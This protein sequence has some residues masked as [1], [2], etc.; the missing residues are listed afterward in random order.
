MENMTYEGCGLNLYGIA[1][2]VVAV[3]AATIASA[4]LV[5]YGLI[6]GGRLPAECGG[7]L[8]QG[9]Q[10]WCGVKWLVLQSFMQQRLGWLSLVCGVAAFALRRRGLAWVGWVSGLGGL[11]LYNFELAAVGG[12]LSLL[13]LTRPTAQERG[14]KD[15]AG[16]QPRDGLGVGRLG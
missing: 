7:S 15:P 11:V 16:E 8:A 3:G 12:M 10:G 6:E 1:A 2:A 9:V 5:R 13:V 4:A 14:G